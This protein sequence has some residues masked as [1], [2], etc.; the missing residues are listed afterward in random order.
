MNYK[1]ITRE[2]IAEVRRLH[3]ELER[4][5]Y[6]SEAHEAHLYAQLEE[7]ERQRKDCAYRAEQ[8]RQDALYDSWER[9]QAMRDLEKAKRWNN[10]WGI[11]KA[12]RKLKRLL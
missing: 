7:K 9:E 10:S 11:A 8:Q 5:R 6:A 12:E 2:L 3:D 1:R 4:E